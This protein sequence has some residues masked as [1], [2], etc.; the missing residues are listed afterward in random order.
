MAES[1]N[2]SSPPL[3]FSSCDCH[4]FFVFF[5]FARFADCQMVYVGILQVLKVGQNQ[6]CWGSMLADQQ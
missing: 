5:F 4:L 1:C 2:S 6:N 3:F